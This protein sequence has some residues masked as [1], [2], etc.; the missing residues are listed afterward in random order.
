MNLSSARRRRSGAPRGFRPRRSRGQNLLVDAGVAEQIIAAA[1]IEPDS[2]VL[3]IGAGTGVLTRP[4]AGM[5]G[6]VVAVE[7]DAELAIALRRRLRGYPN[8]AVLRRDAR[9]LDLE[10]IFPDRP[11]QVVANLPYSVGTP[12]LV[13]LLHSRNRPKRLTVMLQRE[14]AERICADPGDWSALTVM[15]RP[16]GDA[17]I[18]FLVPP[19]AFWPRPKVTSAVISVETTGRDRKDP[20]VASAIWLSR[21]AFAQRRKKLVN[22]IAAGLRLERDAAV[23]LLTAAGI[24]P[25]DRPAN[26]DLPAWLALSDA[27]REEVAGADGSG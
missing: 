24:D 11:Y 5:A 3:E 2:A 17:R 1:R 13:D 12:L 23:N 27:F 20:Q 14:V 16:F 9:A 25:D 19:S 8:V 10:Q 4:L 6:Q 21:H 7:V 18:E 22:S 15:T 26:L